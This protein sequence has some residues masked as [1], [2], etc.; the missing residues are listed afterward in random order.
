MR[1][2][3]QG[4]GSEA[5]WYI[6]G[7]EK[8]RLYIT[9]PQLSEDENTAFLA[10][11]D[12]EDDAVRTI[13]VQETTS[14][15]AG[16]IAA[17]IANDTNR[18]ASFDPQVKMMVPVVMRFTLN[19]TASVSYVDESS[20]SYD[21]TATE[22]LKSTIRRTVT[23][24]LETVKSS[25]GV[26]VESEMVKRLHNNVPE[27]A[28]VHLPVA[29]SAELFNM[30]TGRFVQLAVENR[31]SLDGAPEGSDLSKQITTN[32]TQYYSDDDLIIVNFI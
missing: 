29:T 21:A 7:V 23:E 32:T 24:Y 26:Y 9:L 28:V 1:E 19:I 13:E 10:Q 5:F 22:A 20:S 18:V 12:T 4:D 3:T 14:S 30:K 17:F 8:A 6:P 16:K 2:S 31:F 25:G 15:L 27:I 11:F